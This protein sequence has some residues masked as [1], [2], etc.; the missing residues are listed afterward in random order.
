MALQ[1][2]RRGPDRALAAA[3]HWRVLRDLSSSYWRPVL[4]GVYDYA[5]GDTNPTDGHSATFDV[6]YPTPHDKYGLA[7]QVGWKN[8]HHV[9]SNFDLFGDSVSF[10]VR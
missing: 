9:E 6:L 7:D 2:G 1:G 4:A 3:G 10:G 5:T 8:I